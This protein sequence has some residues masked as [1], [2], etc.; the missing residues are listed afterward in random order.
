MTCLRLGAPEQKAAPC[1]PGVVE[2]RPPRCVEVRAVLLTQ[3][4]NRL[5]V[6]IPERGPI[7]KRRG[8]SIHAGSHTDG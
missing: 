5:T 2:A 3:P 6:H 7:P 4:R 8:T 1:N